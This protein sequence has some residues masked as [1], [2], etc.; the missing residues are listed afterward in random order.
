M[1]EKLWIDSPCSHHFISARHSFDRSDRFGRYSIYFKDD[2]GK[3]KLKLNDI[4][5]PE[6]L[7]KKFRKEIEEASSERFKKKESSRKKQ[8]QE[9][10]GLIIKQREL[11]ALAAKG[12][13]E[14]LPTLR[15]RFGHKASI[16]S[17]D[18]TISD[19]FMK[20]QK[21]QSLIE[22]LSRSKKG[23]ALGS[24]TGAKRLDMS[25]PLNFNPAP[26]TYNVT[27]VSIAVGKSEKGSESMRTTSEHYRSA[28]QLKQ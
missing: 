2:L 15:D 27:R 28:K 7:I 23:K 1:T 26:N 22:K 6:I 16:L 13:T 3:E 17:A 12:R 19:G 5:N 25:R 9:A 14:E 18:T 4:D 10:K 8:V 11:D 24:F 21:H 20:I